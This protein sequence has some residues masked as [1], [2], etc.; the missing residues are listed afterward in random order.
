MEQRSSLTMY[1]EWQVLCN[2][3]RRERIDRALYA[4]Y[5]SAKTHY[6]VEDIGYTPK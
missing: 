4:H 3:N 1:N 2:N 6:S 5:H